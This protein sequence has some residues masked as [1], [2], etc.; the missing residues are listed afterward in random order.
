[1]KIIEAKLQIAFKPISPF[2]TNQKQESIFL[3]V[4]GLVTENIFVSCL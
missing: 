3:E 4:C 1:M 2:R